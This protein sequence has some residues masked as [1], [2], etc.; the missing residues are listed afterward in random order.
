MKHPEPK[1]P[2]HLDPLA[3]EMLAKLREHPEAARRSEREKNAPEPAVQGHCGGA[4]F[5]IFNQLADRMQDN[6]AHT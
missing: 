2:Q 1:I 5:D 3:M 4:T 6:L